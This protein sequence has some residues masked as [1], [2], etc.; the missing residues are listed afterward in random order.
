MRRR[1][2][3]V[4]A[5]GVGVIVLLVAAASAGPVRMWTT[6]PV[7]PSAD[8]T[9]TTGSTVP[10]TLPTFLEPSGLSSR[11]T[12]V[13]QILAVLLLALVIGAGI[14]TA[15]ALRRPTQIAANRAPEGHDASALPD[16]PD[17]DVVEVDLAAARAALAEGSPRNAIVACWM[18]LERDA[19]AAG[20]SRVS[21]ET[22]AEYVARVVASGSVNAGPI[23][24]LA[25]LYRE[26]RFSRHDLGDEH[27]ARALAS[28]ERVAAAL[29]ASTRVSA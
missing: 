25:A 9:R 24:E 12:A 5:A 18:Q 17:R 23:G 16:A 13:L 14:P 28:L 29:R 6:R 4:L 26:A 8:A 22:S 3:L 1:T 2:L 7:V 27:R 10:A 15:R 20:L 19:A 11:T 21:S